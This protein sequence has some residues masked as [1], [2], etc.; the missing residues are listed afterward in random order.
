MDDKTVENEKK[1][2]DNAMQDVIN[3]TDRTYEENKEVQNELV[4]QLQEA[5]EKNEK[6][7]VEM[8]NIQDV[9]KAALEAQKSQYVEYSTKKTEA[10]IESIVKIGESMEAE[11]NAEIERGKKNLVRVE[12][13]LKASNKLNN[14]LREGLLA[15]REPKKMVRYESVM[16]RYS[17]IAA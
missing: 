12:A 5:V 9:C 11:L 3:V 6:L 4:S 2:E 14:I 8:K 7:K 17:K 15:S 13:T 1:K 10:L 16:K